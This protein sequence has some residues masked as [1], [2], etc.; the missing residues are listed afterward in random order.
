MQTE[1][2]HCARNLAAVRP[3]AL[4]LC[5]SFALAGC[6]GGT[7]K[8]A[9]EKTAPPTP[10]PYLVGQRGVST[11]EADALSAISFR[12]FIPTRHYLDVALLPS[13][14]GPDTPANEGIGYEYASTGGRRYVLSEW[15]AN[16]GSVKGYPSLALREAACAD[17][18][19]FPGSTM[20][21]TRGIV[22]M[23]TR[24]SVMTL[25]PDGGSDA[26]TLQAEWRRII[27]RGACR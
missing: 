16:G 27:R 22:W 19:G 3:L 18:H 8:A 9:A 23:T 17:V 6:A 26:R 21:K 25:Q 11:P 2:G 4:V 15:P 7:S 5:A 10:I 24:G 13:F 1:H 14:S 12:P 20:T